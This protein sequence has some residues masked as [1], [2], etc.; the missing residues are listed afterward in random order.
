MTGRL[1][2]LFVWAGGAAFVAALATTAWWYAIR[3]A[4]DRPF[5][6]WPAMA[7]DA[8]LL[9]VFSLHHSAFAREPVKRRVASA[10]PVRLLR[11]VYVWTASVLLILV[12]VLWEPVGGTV[13]EISGS[14][15]WMFTA[16]QVV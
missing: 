4:A 8:V 3:F 1:E 14:A 15:A 7:A 9:S 11:S 2:R 6:G 5:S 12:N 13:Y 10:I 16:V